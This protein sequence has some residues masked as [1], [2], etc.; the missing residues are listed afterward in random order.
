MQQVV[1]KT[2]EMQAGTRCRHK[3]VVRCPIIS[4]KD[5]ILHYELL[6]GTATQ[7]PHQALGGTLSSLYR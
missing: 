6:K 3:E 5:G 4:Y 2:E 1:K 7:V